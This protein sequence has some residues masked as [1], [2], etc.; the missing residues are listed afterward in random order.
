[1]YGTVSSECKYDVLP[2]PHEG[3]LGKLCISKMLTVKIERSPTWG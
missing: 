3:R 2:Q 1:M